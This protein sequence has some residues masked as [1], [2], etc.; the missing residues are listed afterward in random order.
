MNRLQV[1][2]GRLCDDPPGVV[3][4]ALQTLV[5]DLPPALN[6]PEQVIASSVLSRSLVQIARK[7]GFDENAQMAAAIVTFS[8]RDPADDWHA[9]CARAA[10]RC[11]GLFVGAPPL[12]P[13]TAESPKVA[14][15]L[16]TLDAHFRNPEFGAQDLA[17]AVDLSAS[18]APRLLKRVTGAGLVEHVRRRRIACAR[19]LL[20]TTSLG[21]KEVAAAA[22]YTNASHFARQFKDVCGVT[23]RG[24]RTTGLRASSRVTSDHHT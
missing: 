23:A 24:Y 20:A 3:I 5:A 15:M 19:R 7:G 17:R 1:L 16:S 10:A 2:A 14:L 11:A 22:G 9:A 13:R 4:H 12:D 21:I 8:A 18:H 6:Q